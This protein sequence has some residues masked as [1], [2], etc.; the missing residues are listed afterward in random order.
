MKQE[1]TMP[2]HEVLN[3]VWREIKLPMEAYKLYQHAQEE[4]Q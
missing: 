3:N 4:E 2:F 1:I